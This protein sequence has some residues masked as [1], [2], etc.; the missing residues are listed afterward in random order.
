MRYNKFKKKTLE[1]FIRLILSISSFKLA[2]NIDDLFNR[3]SIIEYEN[4]I[5]DF[6]NYLKQ[7]N[8]NNPIEIF[9]Y[10][11]Y[12]L[13][14]GYLSNNHIY[15]YDSN[16]DILISNPG[17]TCI[18]GNGVC[19]NK[20]DSYNAHTLNCYVNSELVTI[21]IIRTNKLFDRNISEDPSNE[22]LEKFINAIDPLIKL[23][24]NHAITCVEYEGIFYFFDSTNLIYLQK[25]DF[26]T[27]QI[28]NGSGSF[29]LKYFSSLF[30]NDLS[31]IEVI[32]D[33]GSYDKEVLE[34]ENVEI[35]LE[36]L[37]QFYNQEKYY[38]QQ[39]SEHLEQKNQLILSIIS[40]FISTNLVHMFYDEIN[41]LGKK[42]IEI[43]S[44]DSNSD[45]KIKVKK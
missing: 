7:N 36:S 4:I 18:A 32:D 35:D 20:A 34:S 24:G 43:L 29:D 28:I 30:Y 2:Q 15:Q 25:I 27:I 3:N 23:I 38:Y 11:N 13:W 17:L 42:I 33:I 5:D 12:A 16:R 45:E 31:S 44:K 37:E 41:L 10:Y 40:L 8:I 26:N 6:T 22:V 39:V 1:I 19:L 14:N 9:D 21:D